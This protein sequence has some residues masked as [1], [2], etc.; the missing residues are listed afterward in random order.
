MFRLGG[1]GAAVLALAASSVDGQRADAGRCPAGEQCADD[2]PEGLQFEGAQVSWFIG[3]GLATTAVGGY[4]VVRVTDNATGLPLD[5]PFL[6]EA[7]NT[8]AHA[9]APG[10][11]PQVAL[12]ASAEGQGFLRISRVA[13]DYLF[14]RIAI[15]SRPIARIAARPTLRTSWPVFGGGG[16]AVLAGGSAEIAIALYGADDDW[17]IDESMQIATPTPSQRT[18][19]DAVVISPP[20]AGV[21]RIGVTAGDGVTAELLVDAVD[22]LAAVIARTPE[23]SA[24]VGQS[25]DVCFDARS[26]DERSVYGSAWSFEIT[27]DAVPNPAADQLYPHCVN[28]RAT[29]PGSVRVIATSSGRSAL[30]TYSITGSSSRL[31]APRGWLSGRDLGERAAT[32]ATAED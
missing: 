24:S 5:V 4:Q 19:W 7:T 21:Y 3:N 20:D 8:G 10:D 27:G 18:G 14:D 23:G 12:S 17:L 13:D 1:V 31:V 32:A 15:D 26:F 9:A 11:G 25:F 6:A 28:L 16:W 22:S 2:T 29:N 30:S